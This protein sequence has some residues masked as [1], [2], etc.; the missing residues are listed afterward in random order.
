MNTT[1]T[2]HAA[3]VLFL[4]VA[5]L[6]AASLPVA[7]AE[8][9]AVSEIDCRLHRARWGG[10]A[11]GRWRTTVRADL[12]ALGITVKSRFLAKDDFNTGNDVR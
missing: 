12:E 5:A 7:A 3:A 1:M 8:V 11:G 6:A 4:L 9:V 2:R 10:D